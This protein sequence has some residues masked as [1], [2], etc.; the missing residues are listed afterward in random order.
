MLVELGEK[1]D[2]D[3]IFRGIPTV[4]LLKRARL[5]RNVM[6]REQPLHFEWQANVRV[7]S[8]AVGVGGHEKLSLSFP[9]PRSH[10]SF[11]L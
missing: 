5:P 9:A 10:I 1:G 6:T 3:E 11:R 8:E 7:T 2:V 4:S